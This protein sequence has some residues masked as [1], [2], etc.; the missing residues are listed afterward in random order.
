MSAGDRENIMGSICGGGGAAGGT[1]SISLGPGAGGGG[2]GG[3]SS[4]ESK[5]PGLGFETKVNDRM[6]LVDYVFAEMCGGSSLPSSE[7]PSTLTLASSL[8]SLNV[9]GQGPSGLDKRDKRN[10]GTTAHPP[11]STSSSSN[12]N[13]TVMTGG[14]AAK[15]SL[16]VDS[17]DGAPTGTEI[18]LQS[19]NP[20]TL[21]SLEILSTQIQI[22]LVIVLTLQHKTCER[23][24]CKDTF[25]TLPSYHPFTHQL[26][27]PPTHQPTNPPTHSL[28]PTPSPTHP[29]C[30]RFIAVFCH[31]IRKEGQHGGS[32]GTKAVSRT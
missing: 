14:G 30:R 25:L 32:W 26:A 19:Y 17:L 28:T 22:H 20:T 31:G 6:E 8:A 4:G 18:T 9:Q 16:G 5:E 27:H 24:L 23:I 1:P 11:L 13:T 12:I 21:Q 7:R 10:V 3:G 2:G 29:L 15:S